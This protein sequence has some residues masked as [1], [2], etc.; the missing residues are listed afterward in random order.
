MGTELKIKRLE[1]D[2]VI[3]CLKRRIFLQFAENQPP[4]SGGGFLTLWA[5]VLWSIYAPNCVNKS[6]SESTFFC[7]EK[8]SPD[9][10][11][12]LLGDS[13]C[14]TAA[15]W[16]FNGSLT[17][18]SVEIPL[19]YRRNTVELPEVGRPLYVSGRRLATFFGGLGKKVYLCSLFYI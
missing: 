7:F 8:S 1:V 16:Q 13:H 10:P 5:S 14:S 4:F 15:Q 18:K 9:T 19:K 17:V 12:C 11:S 3:N 2:K 6:S